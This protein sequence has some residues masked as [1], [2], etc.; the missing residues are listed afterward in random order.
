MSNFHPIEVV[1]RDSES[2]LQVGENFYLY[3]LVL[4]GLT[5]LTVQNRSLIPVLELI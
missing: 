2:Q 4:Q 5:P 1:G 3:N